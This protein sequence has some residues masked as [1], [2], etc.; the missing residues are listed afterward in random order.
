MDVSIPEMDGLAATQAIRTLLD[1]EKQPYI[2]ALTANGIH[3]DAERYQAAVLN[4]YLRKPIQVPDLIAALNHVPPYHLR[5][6]NQRLA[7][8][9]DT[10]V[11]DAL[12]DTAVAVDPTVLTEIVELM[13][14][15]G[16]TMVRDLIQLFLQNSPLLLEQLWN[17]LNKEDA[18]AFFR[19]VH[20][21]RTPAAQVGAFHLSALCHEV[22]KNSET[23]VTQRDSNLIDQLDAEYERVRHYFLVTPGLWSAIP[24]LSADKPAEQ[25][26][27]NEGSFT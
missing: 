8:G 17:A 23:I 19:A 26:M 14:E 15:E 25:V 11:G 5:A 27:R 7:M 3:E 2:I 13:G 6:D 20:T 4:Y 12:S 18:G 1:T 24:G 21:L 9:N 22:E 10:L 16:I